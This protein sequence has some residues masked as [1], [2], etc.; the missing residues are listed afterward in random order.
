MRV[1][2]LFRE[3]LAWAAGLYDGEGCFSGKCQLVN[4]DLELIERFKEIVGFGTIRPR[5]KSP[6][7]KHKPQWL[8]VSSSFEEQ[9]ALICFLW[10]WLSEKR[11]AQALKLLAKKRE[12]GCRPGGIMCRK[13]LHRLEG[14]NV[15]INPRKNR[16][17][18]KSFRSC[19][20]CRKAC[21]LGHY[22]RSKEK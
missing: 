19:R 21:S 3:R 7:I 11:K 5:A 9:Q 13:G 1:A 22:Y 20:A 16:E 6:N 17:G 14:D 10:E 4:T 12:Q 15:Y 18:G 2:S 8:W